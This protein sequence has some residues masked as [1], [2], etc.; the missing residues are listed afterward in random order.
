MESYAMPKTSDRR[1]AVLIG[2]DRYDTPFVD[3]LFGCVEDVRLTEGYLRSLANI[4]NISK[5]TSPVDPDPH[6]CLTNLL[7]TLANVIN[8]LETLAANAREKDFIY[9]HYSGHG[10]RLPTL[11]DLKNGDEDEA[12]L[13]VSESGQKVDSLRDVEL[14][15]LLNAI[16][17]RGAIV[18]IVLDCCHSAGATRS[19]AR[20]SGI[21]GMGKIPAD[22]LVARDA[23]YPESLLQKSWLARG[24]S[25][26][27]AA[28][29]MK[30]WMTSSIGIE[31]LAACL[32]N[33]TAQEIQPPN[34]KP[35]GLF[36]S[37]L[38]GVLED[39][40]N[41]V[42]DLTCDMVYNLVARKVATHED[43]KRRQDVVFGGQRSRGF[44]LVGDVSQAVTTV[45]NTTYRTDGLVHLELNAG[46]AHAVV[47]GDEFALYSPDKT[48]ADIT[49]YHS[50]LAICKVFAVNDFV[51][52]AVVDVPR[53]TDNKSDNH[54]SI[55]A[56][57]KAVLL[58]NILK[59]HV[60]SPRTVRVLPYG[61]E[62]PRQAVEAVKDRV[63]A[64]GKIIELDDLG[65]SSFEV[66]VKRENCFEISFIHNTKTGVKAMVRTHSV[67]ALLLLLAHLAIYY[68]ILDLDIPA[69]AGGLVVQATGVLPAGIQPPK[70]LKISDGSTPLNVSGVESL[71]FS[72]PLD[73]PDGA[74][75]RVRV[76]N[77]SFKPIY[78]EILNL[79]PSWQ[80]IDF[81]ITMGISPIPSGSIQTETFDTILVLGTTSD[82]T[83][84]PSTVLPQLH[85]TSEGW[86]SSMG[87][88]WSRGLSYGARLPQWYVQR[89]DVRAVPAPR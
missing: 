51:S 31:F 6:G 40:R 60:T 73:I 44:F 66:S 37:C 52:Q 79:E 45:T 34:K 85:E 50:Y 42:G 83:N 81:F 23:L 3:D 72:D 68:N 88:I 29:V 56:G 46:H 10:A 21:R 17:E 80:A 82:R 13:L 9:I 41:S 76:R 33:Q 22:A 59:R 55:Q 5:L 69:T 19:V 16:T 84:F 15:F 77:T 36:T 64:D 53:D 78:I 65:S 2:I 38:L 86:A 32:A 48:L 25:S 4:S 57:C 74:S 18:T 43:S 47:D 39:N 26:G 75:L 70:P 87:L 58:R 63:R 8:V 54:F 35:R 71:E 30:H 89:L 12:L 67:D 62:V 14:A 49:D 61:E 28:S 1:F 20:L 27:R 24:K 7:P 11:F